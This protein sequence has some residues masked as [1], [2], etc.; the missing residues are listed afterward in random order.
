[1]FTSK[2]SQRGLTMIELIVFIIIV[3]VAVLA[4]L[5]VYVIT[6]RNSA[7]PQMR[8]QA[9]AL[10]EAFLEEVELARFT[11][12]EPVLD[13]SA[14][15]PVARPNPAACN[16]LEVVGQEV[17]SV[18]R[19]FDNVNDYVNQFNVATPAF[20]SG[21]QLIDAAG[22]VIDLPGYSVT[23]TI[24]PEAL[25]GINSGATAATMEVLR[26]SVTVTYNN[27]SDSLTLDGYRTRYAPN[28]VP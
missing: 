23:L 19:P 7:D 8:K 3:S 1:M 22:E 25:N 10:A 26:I 12:C 27:G 2:S 4:L 15:D 17:G 11:Y 16:V 24:V 28:A 5:R 13:G 6:S 21:T 9:L 14:D 20:N 18:N